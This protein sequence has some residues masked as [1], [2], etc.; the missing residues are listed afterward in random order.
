[1]QGGIPTIGAD[2]AFAIKPAGG[3]PEKN[4]PIIGIR[5]HRAHGGALQALLKI[6]QLKDAGKSLPG[7]H[8]AMK[9]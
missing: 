9:A 5:V 7:A 4:L 8:A 2:H 1:M 6:G 3:N